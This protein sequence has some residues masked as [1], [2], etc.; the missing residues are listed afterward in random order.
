MNQLEFSEISRM[1]CN[2]RCKQANNSPDLGVIPLRQQT[3]PV[4]CGFWS[5]WGEFTTA[6]CLPQTGSQVHR[7]RFGGGMCEGWASTAECQSLKTT[8][9]HL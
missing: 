1:P 8:M 4:K 9:H 3:Q 7:L 6:V 2:I 5:L